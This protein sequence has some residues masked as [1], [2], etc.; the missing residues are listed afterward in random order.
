MA[1]KLAKEHILML[2][3]INHKSDRV[4]SNE[5]VT[6]IYKSMQQSKRTLKGL[7]ETLQFDDMQ[8]HKLLIQLVFCMQRDSTD[9]L[10]EHTFEY[11]EGLGHIIPFQFASDAG[12]RYTIPFFLFG[13]EIL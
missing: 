7:Q 4:L 2:Q 12:R 11:Y 5:Q 13:E 6:D 3:T 8:F 1:T 10:G 9:M